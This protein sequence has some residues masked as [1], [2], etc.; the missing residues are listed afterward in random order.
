MNNHYEC[1]ALSRTGREVLKIFLENRHNYHG[2][3]DGDDFD[4]GL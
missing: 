2:H 3:E 4:T 1:G